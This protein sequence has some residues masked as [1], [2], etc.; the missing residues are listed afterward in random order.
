MIKINSHLKYIA[1]KVIIRSDTEQRINRND[2]YDKKKFFRMMN[3]R[4]TSNHFL[5]NLHNINVSGH[6]IFLNNIFT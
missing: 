3:K 2:S 4:G 6:K 1:K 5:L